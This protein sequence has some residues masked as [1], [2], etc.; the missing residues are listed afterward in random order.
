MLLLAP[1]VCALHVDWLKSAVAS[2]MTAQLVE[3]Q[4]CFGNMSY[5]LCMHAS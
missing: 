5:K 1:S 2:L 3:K 4:G